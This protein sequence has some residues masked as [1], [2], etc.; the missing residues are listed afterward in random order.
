MD[1]PGKGVKDAAKKALNYFKSGVGGGGKFQGSGRKLG[2]SEAGRPPA[3]NAAALKPPA[4]RK[5]LPYFNRDGP[6]PS[7]PPLQPDARVTDELNI[8]AASIASSGPSGAEASKTLCAIIGNVLRSPGEQKFRQL[9]C[10]NARV[11]GTLAVPGAIDLLVQLGFEHVAA[12]ASTSSSGPKP[13][14]PTAP[15]GTIALPSRFPGEH[16]ALFH[17]ALSLLRPLV[18]DVATGAQQPAAGGAGEAPA[19]AP[20]QAPPAPASPSPPPAPV[21]QPLPEPGVSA[22]QDVDMQESP[23]PDAAAPAAP[24]PARRPAASPPKPAAAPPAGGGGGLGMSREEWLKQNKKKRVISVGGVAISAAKSDPKQPDAAAPAKPPPP[25][26]KKDEPEEYSGRNT[27]VLLPTALG[28]DVP[29]WF[30]DRTGA[31]L[32]AEFQR[33]RAAREL[34]E[35]LMTRAHREKLT[36][37]GRKQHKFATIRVRFPEGVL[38]QGCFQ[39]SAPTVEIHAWVQQHVRELAPFQLSSPALPGRGKH[40][41]H[42]GTVASSGLMPSFLLNFRWADGPVDGPSLS[43]DAM[44]MAQMDE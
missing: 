18:A 7:P 2:S 16:E 36:Q 9:K 23:A 26:P 32:K 17:G 24:P 14:D 44:A 13:F 43:D 15:S 35:T 3:R 38:L 34:R 12:E 37:A 30:F 6:L 19:A 29:E 28:S 21:P 8:A 25:A 39:P 11:A 20:P 1:D 4:P 27:M 33:T 42:D 5:P 40:L 10:S 22:R 41:A 31:D